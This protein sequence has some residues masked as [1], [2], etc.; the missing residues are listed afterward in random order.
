MAFS[1]PSSRCGHV[2]AKIGAKIYMWGGTGSSQG[3]TSHLNRVYIFDNV[4]EKWHARKTTGRLPSGYQFC[5]SVQSGSVLY[6][7]GGQDENRVRRGSLHSL[8]LENFSWT[9]LSPEVR[10]GPQKKCSTRMTIHGN[11]IFLFGGKVVRRG[12]VRTNELH[13][14]DLETSMNKY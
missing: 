11:K 12:R 6:V 10:N 14:F 7:Y 3:N 2:T 5:A 13:Q 1:E 8:N 4:R 9:E